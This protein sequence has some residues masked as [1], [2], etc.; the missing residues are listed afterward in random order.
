MLAVG[1]G[2]IWL[3]RA[4]LGMPDWVVAQIET[5]L[6][7]MLQP[8]D[9]TARFDRLS[10][11]L[12][13][14]FLPSVTVEGLNLSGPDGQAQLTLARLDAVLSARAALDGKLE[15][16][17]LRLEGL[18]LA[19]QRDADG[20]LTIRLGSE[21]LVDAIRTPGDIVARLRD[22]LGT[23]PLASVDAFGISG[24]SM[25]YEDAQRKSAVTSRGGSLRIL[26]AGE[27]LAFNLDMGEIDGVSGEARNGRISAELV[28]DSSG[29]SA[30]ARLALRGIE[31]AS[32]A[33]LAGPSPLSNALSKVAA[34]ISLTLTAAMDADGLFEGLSG[35][36]SVGEGL[37]DMPGLSEPVPL[38]WARGDLHLNGAR[39]RVVLSNLDLSSQQIALGGSLTLIA[40]PEDPV[41]GPILAQ[42]DLSR[43]VLTQPDIYAEPMALDGLWADLR[44]NR[45]S[46]AVTIGNLVLT[47]GVTKIS[48]SGRVARD[49]EDGPFALALDL[50]V[51]QMTAESFLALWPIPLKPRTRAW[52]TKHILEGRLSNLNA[53]IRTSAET[54]P[55]LAA[56]F[57]FEDAVVQPL[58]RLGPL[59]HVRGQGTI[60]DNRLTITVDQ[61]RLSPPLGQTIDLSEGVILVPDMRVKNGFLGVEFQADS[62]SKGVLSLLELPGLRN[63]DEPPPK[64][65][66]LVS[67]Q[68]ATGTVR[69][70]VGMQIPTI[71]GTKMKNVDFTVSGDVTGFTSD[72]VVPGRTL[73]AGTVRIAADQS[74]LTLDGPATIDGNPI[75]VRFQRTLGEPDPA[76]RVATITAEAAL[77][78]ELAEEFGVKL[79]AGAVSGAGRVTAVIIATP[80]TPPKLDLSGDLAGLGLSIP[81]LGLQKSSRSAGTL[82][83]SGTLGPETTL[84]RISVRAPGL[85]L[86]G[87]AKVAASGGGA[88]L[89]FGK[90]QI[91]RWL[92]VTGRMAPGTAGA[93]GPVTITG[94]T[95]DLR[96]APFGKSGAKQS[97]NPP[98]AINLD[99]LVVNDTLSMS[100]LKGS[101]SSR[102]NGNFTS[103][104]NGKE[105]VAIE[106]GPAAVGRAIAVTAADAGAVLASAGL[107]ANARG[108]S[109]DLKLFPEA[110]QGR[111]RGQLRIR[112]TALRDSPVMA[113]LL[114]AI[115][116]VGAIQQMAGQG[117]SFS[118]VRADFQM[119]PGQI[120]VLTSSAEGP[121]IGI[122]LDGIIN[123][124]G[125]SLDLQGVVSP[126]YFINQ[127]GSFMTR[128]GEGLLGVSYKIRGPIAKPS[129]A[130]NPLSMLTPGFLRD[131]F[132]SP[133]KRSE[134]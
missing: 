61:A 70:A 38:E 76:K 26:R 20:R 86:D 120:R 110:G 29:G 7:E 28:T 84:E 2:V 118:D 112:D 50:R 45:S 122:S 68:T 14:G 59:R 96:H 18:A 47:Q 91:G 13:D 32:V 56:S 85:V 98:L 63:P 106:I 125:K 79:P 15:P 104:V 34:P 108:G 77:T 23:G 81:G 51:P 134:N 114:S 102:G 123:T 21:T 16:K 95:V 25:R 39:D 119:E 22:V 109:F 49:P 132:R 83:V 33:G 31:P 6:D 48:A 66:P 115:S 58:T 127:A 57:R 113:E 30:R 131:I 89:A 128:R 97:R 42:I 12:R 19:V 67:S 10:V 116:V 80:G 65:K 92:D 17:A 126:I 37:I 117:I 100:R 133:I 94:G 44:F 52:M 111:F 9:L 46:G 53:S 73:E 69:L 71:Q 93:P 8:A 74:S 64:S 129:V 78:R 11:G 103:R 72:T 75:Q 105:P 60:T 24:L 124:K 87:S 35:Q 5:R 3:K 1:G 107:F 101:L 62:D 121:S 4:S 54:R 43:L 130:V 90:L 36:I 88:S 27:E 40:A 99:N 41:T 55:V 82:K